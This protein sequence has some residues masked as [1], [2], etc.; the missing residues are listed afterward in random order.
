MTMSTL[1]NAPARRRALTMAVLA[2]AAVVVQLVVRPATW[3]SALT[4]SAPAY[5]YTVEDLGVFPDGGGASLATGIN[6]AGD[7]SGYANHG[8]PGYTAFRWHD[9]T[10]T[11]FGD[12][13]CGAHGNAINDSGTVVGYSNVTCGESDKAGFQSTQT[14]LQD[15]GNFPNGG[16]PTIANAINTSGQIVGSSVTE[17]GT[18]RAFITGPGGVG[19][20]QLDDLATEPYGAQTLE[21]HGVNSTGDVTGIA[22]FFDQTC[23]SHDAPFLFSGG[24]IQELGGLD[25]SGIGTAVNDAGQVVGYE[26]S[27][28]FMWDGTIHDLGLPDG[29]AISQALA[30]NNGGT[31]VG[32]SYGC[33]ICPPQAWINGTTPLNS[34]IDPALGWNLQVAAGINDRGQIA[35]YGGH[36]G[37]VHAFRLTPVA[38]TLTSIAV[39]PAAPT[40]PKG[41]SRQFTATGTYSDGSTADLTGS[42]T[43]SSSSTKVATIDSSGLLATLTKGSTTVNATAG[44]LSGS[45]SVTVGSAKLV[46]AAIAPLNP[47]VLAG[48]AQQFTATGTFSDGTTRDL[49]TKGAWASSNKKVATIGRG[50]GLATAVK[51]GSTTI[52]FSPGGVTVTTT[53]TV[54]SV[55]TT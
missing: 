7:V 33:Q 40:I 43:W 45:T 53:L 21:A 35:G 24:T 16:R 18:G 11:D 50:S 31:I 46:S 52:K 25:C 36:N 30:I 32:A 38:R 8:T 4:S 39:T 9:G 17:H 55:G 10:L 34:L 41:A 28:A 47:T 22:F 48:A 15:I 2:L 54:G 44:S 19:L 42:V 3:A 49:T 5:A 27:H 12:L 37:L 51:D 20:Q 13:G 23:G 1:I 29:A 14:G 6:A 26:G